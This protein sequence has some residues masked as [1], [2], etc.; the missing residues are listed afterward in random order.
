MKLLLRA[1]RDEDMAVINEWP[2]Y[3]AEFGELDYALRHTGWLREFAHRPGC[4]CFA[5]EQ[6]DELIAFTILAGAGDG[7]AEFRIALRG[8]LTGQGLGRSIALLTLAQGF[9]RLGLTRIELIVR[10][11]HQRALALYHRLGF[12]PE[13]ECRKKINGQLVPCV[14]MALTREAFIQQ[15]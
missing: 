2:P 8:D 5:V 14:R 13:G 9:D 6:A 12:L 10:T 1:L 4:S 3:P 7:A 15:G 11:N